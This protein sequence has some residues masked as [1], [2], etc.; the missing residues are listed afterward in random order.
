M[1]QPPRALH[2][3]QRRGDEP[4]QPHERRRRPL[5]RYLRD[6]PPVATGGPEI[7]EPRIYYGEETD[8]Y[9]MVKGSTPEF[10]YPK[11]KDNVYAAYD[12]TGGVPGGRDRAEDSSPGTS[13]TRTAA[14]KL[15]RQR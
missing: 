1:G 2:P 9:V 10:D 14:L 5:F 12:G 15:H 11:G 6:I 7:R 4:G 13:T 8:N 3:R